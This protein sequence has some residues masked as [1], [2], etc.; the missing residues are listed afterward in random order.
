MRTVQ[1][2]EGADSS[3]CVGAQLLQWCL[4]LCDPVDCSPSG[5]SVLGILEAR[6]GLLGPPPGDLPNP[7]IE[8]ASHVSSTGR[9]VLYH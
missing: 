5:F 2:R 7:G 1:P 9:Q 6:S 4:T 3:A 8:P